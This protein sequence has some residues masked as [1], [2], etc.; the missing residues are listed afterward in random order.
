VGKVD[1]DRSVGDQLYEIIDE[2]S[3]T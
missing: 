3:T 2:Q 1:V